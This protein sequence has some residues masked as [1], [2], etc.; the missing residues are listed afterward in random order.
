MQRTTVQIAAAVLATIVTVSGLKGI[1]ALAHS[2][3]RAPTQLVVLPAVE[4]I[5]NRAS[6]V[7]DAA[8]VRKL[9]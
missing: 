6:L 1:A 4:V 7:A 2:E 5:A 9:R 8:P 3:A